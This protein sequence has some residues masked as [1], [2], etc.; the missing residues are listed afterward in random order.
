MAAN[1]FQMPAVGYPRKTGERP[2]RPRHVF[3]RKKAPMK[4]ALPDLDYDYSALEPHYSAAM[5]ELR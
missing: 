1:R 4:Y 3:V 2:K 5:L